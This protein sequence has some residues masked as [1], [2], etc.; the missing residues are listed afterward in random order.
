MERETVVSTMNK[1]LC[2]IIEWGERNSVIFN[3]S[4]TQLCEIS[5]LKNKNKNETISFDSTPLEKESSVRLL[6]VNISS[7]LLWHDHVMSIA[8]QASKK[9][10]FLYRCK[11]F[12]NAQQLCLIYKSFIRPCMEYC[13]HVWGAAAKTTLDLLDRVQN[14]AIRLINDSGITNKLDSLKH[15]RDVAD[16]TIFY[17]Y[18]YGHCSKEVSEIMPSREKRVRKTRAGTTPPGRAVTLSTVRTSKFQ[19]DFF[20]RTAKKWNSLPACAFP[21]QFNIQS[22]KTNVHKY[23]ISNPIN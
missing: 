19:N 20:T 21:K 13:C 7:N 6:G 11:S 22:F 3:A 23:L 2:R 16:L 14:R 4:K 15:R 12:F 1:D 9:L 5:R 10:G 18:S 17:K 8:K